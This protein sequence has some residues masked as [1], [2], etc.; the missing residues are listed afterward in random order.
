MT[1]KYYIDTSIWR[2]YYENR[3]DNFRPLG[4]WALDF[5]K[6]A[7]KE[8]SLFLYSDIVDEE[9]KKE[10]G[11]DKIKDILD[12][13]NRINLLE[14]V[15]IIDEQIKEASKLS[16]NYNI[17]FGDALHAILARD[18]NAV[19]ITRDLHFNELRNIVTVKKPEELI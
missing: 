2:D 5:F 8:E 1:T 16:K 10:Y 9:L 17:P 18:N 4:E 12:I 6:K 7:I 13:I 11:E 15:K 19:M 3:N 14:K